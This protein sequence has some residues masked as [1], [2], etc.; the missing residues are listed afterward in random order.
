MIRPRLRRAHLGNLAVLG[1]IALA[2][3]GGIFSVF[4]TIE[5]E[6]SE[7]AQMRET[8]EILLELRNITRMALNGETGQRGYLLTL[9][10]RYLDP[11]LVGRDQYPV[12]PVVQIFREGT[13]A[14]RDHG[15]AVRDR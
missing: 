12:R 6:R 10:R 5:A 11:Y 1:L 3:F 15:P 2:L 8:S 13:D 9:D 7:R 14:G 4:Q